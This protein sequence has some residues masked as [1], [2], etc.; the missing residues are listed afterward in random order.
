MPATFLGEDGQG[1]CE[2]KHHNP[3]FFKQG[4]LTLPA[5]GPIPGAELEAELSVASRDPSI[6]SL[7]STCFFSVRVLEG[8][9]GNRGR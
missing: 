6:F 9:M 1:K 4:S 3:W 7:F 2:Q 5:L 8:S